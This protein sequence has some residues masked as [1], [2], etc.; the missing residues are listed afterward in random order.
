MLSWL[1]E[2]QA[3]KQLYWSGL[4]APRCGE[5]ACNVKRWIQPKVWE[6]K[7]AALEAAAE[8]VTVAAS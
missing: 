5:Q 1:G 8:G 7:Q 2:S 4:P 3:A 6:L